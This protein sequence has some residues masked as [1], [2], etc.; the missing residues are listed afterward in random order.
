MDILKDIFY[1]HP[2]NAILMIIFGIFLLKIYRNYRNYAK[3]SLTYLDSI[4]ERLDLLENPV[5]KNRGRP[6]KLKDI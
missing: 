5:K 1:I 6:K 2:M 4:E 3:D